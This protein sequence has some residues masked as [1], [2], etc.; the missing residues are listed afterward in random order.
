SVLLGATGTGPI[1]GLAFDERRGILFGIEGGPAPADLLTLDLATGRATVVGSTAIQAGSLEFGP[2]GNLYAGGTGSN[3]GNLYRIDPATGAATFVGPTGFPDVTGLTLV[4]T[5][6][7][8]DC[9]R[10]AHQGE[11]DAAING[12]ACGPPV[13]SAGS[14]LQV[15]CVSL[16]GSPV[17]LEGSGSIDPNSTPGTSDD[18]VRF[19]WFEDFGLPSQTLLQIGEVVEV[20]FP[21]GEHDVSL[22]VT[23]RFGD[24]DVDEMLVTIVDTVAPAIDVSVGLSILWPPNHRLVPISSSVLASDACSD[25]E[26]TIL[27]IA[28]NE[29]DDAPGSGDGSTTGDIQVGPGPGDPAFS[30]RAERAGTGG[31]RVYTVVYGATDAAGQVGTSTALVS[32]PLAQEGGSEPLQIFLSE[33]GAGTMVEWNPVVGS[34][35]Y[36]LVRG[37]IENL[38]DRPNFIDLGAVACLAPGITTTH[39]DGLEDAIHP[40]VGKAFF[41]LVEFNNGNP[42]GFGTVS[43]PKPRVAGPG[44]CPRP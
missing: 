39:S 6:V 5:P 37:E 8:M 25:P 40:A 29:P 34:L 38:Q 42:S 23:D 35:S 22:K 24:F 11:I 4:G 10:F 43:A 3:S 16:N 21:R 33:N 20:V 36:A 9:V 27:S 18:I 2:D 7:R 14:D 41:Y 26:V 31:G 1:S 12:A 15:E 17:V 13:A 32:V 19:E 44:D 30:L 28:S